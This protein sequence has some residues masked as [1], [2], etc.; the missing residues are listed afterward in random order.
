MLGIRLGVDIPSSRGRVRPRT[1]GPSVTFDDV[2]SLPR[3][4]LPTSH[5]GTGKDPVFELDELDLGAGLA[6]RIDPDDPTHGFIEPARE[7]SMYEFRRH[8]EMTREQWRR[9]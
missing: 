3:H 9:V 8:V 1:G 6:L 4:R 5:G 2:R 7:M